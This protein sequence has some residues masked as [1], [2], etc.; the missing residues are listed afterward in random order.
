VP[1]D[2]V[3]ILDAHWHRLLMPH[4]PLPACGQ[5]RRTLPLPQLG[6]PALMT[7][8]HRTALSV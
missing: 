1:L 2:R 6:S 4:P 3:L 8:P 5:Q 7:D